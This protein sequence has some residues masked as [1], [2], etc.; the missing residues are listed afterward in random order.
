M[1]RLE[2]KIVKVKEENK[3]ERKE[4]ELTY[5]FMREPKFGRGSKNVG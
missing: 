4:K 3:K 5:L 1:I 2:V